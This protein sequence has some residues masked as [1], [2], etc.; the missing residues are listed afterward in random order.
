VEIMTTHN[1]RSRFSALEKY[2]FLIPLILFV[3][4]LAIT[5]PGISWGVPSTWHPDE[6]VV[7]SLKALHGEWQFDE[8]NFDYPSLPQYVMYW[9]GRVMLS[10]GKTDIDVWV[11]SRVLSAIL[12][13]L[14]IVLTYF[15]A[16][17]ITN[18][19]RLAGLS[20]LLLFSVSE[21]THNGRFAHNDTYVTFFT[22]LFLFFLV[23]YTKSNRKGWLYAAFVA[24]GMAASSKYN[25]IGLVIVPVLMYLFSLRR[26]IFK[27][28]LEIGETLFIGSVLTFLGFAAGTPKSLF[29]MSFYFKRMIPALIRTGNYARQPGSVRGILGQYSNFIDG[30]GWPLFCCFWR[31]FFGFVI[32]WSRRSAQ[33]KWMSM[34]RCALIFHCSC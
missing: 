31:P 16:R 7:R 29:W 25:G 6:I 18:N 27:H 32:G 10:L 15:I 3:L 28:M 22:C 20:G 21:M 9:L 19:V 34:I 8:I 4:F 26:S 14:T 2:E 24:V 12:A 11:A 5:L 1:L 30:V 17:K 23:H 13:G 33:N